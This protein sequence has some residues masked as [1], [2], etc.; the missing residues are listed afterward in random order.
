MKICPQ[1]KGIG[2]VPVDAKNPGNT[3]RCTECN[4]TG[5]APETKNQ[6]PRTKKDEK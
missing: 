3:R 2:S 5:L 6:E 1:C 4:G